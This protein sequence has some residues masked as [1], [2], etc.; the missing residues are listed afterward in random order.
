MGLP[1]Q[2]RTPRSKKERASHFA[3]KKTGL[4]KCSECGASVL[5]HHACPKCGNYK[6]KKV[7]DTKK[8]TER[9]IRRNKKR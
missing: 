3:I 8:R 9:R 4:S 6:G 7:I 5:P 1:S 2:R